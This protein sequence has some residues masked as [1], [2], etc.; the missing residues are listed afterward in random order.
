M[1]SANP[2]SRTGFGKLP[3]R[4]TSV[5]MPMLLSILMTCIVSLISTLMSDGLAIGVW[6]RS[7]A[8][9]WPI[10]FPTLLLVLPAVRRITAA[11]V[12]APWTAGP[13]HRPIA[14]PR[15]REVAPL[16]CP[17]VRTESPSALDDDQALIATVPRPDV[18]MLRPQ[19]MRDVVDG[20]REQGRDQQ[21]VNSH[22]AVGCP[23]PLPPKGLR[24]PHT[25]PRPTPRTGCEIE[26]PVGQPI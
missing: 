11:L 21:R 9:S 8:V 13:S 4:Y 7:W 12:Q 16:P 6:L 26:T 15:P 5:I 22:P 23:P 20:L 17:S 10:A 14:S 19:T 18:K 24:K 2:Q 25:S 3:A 1:N